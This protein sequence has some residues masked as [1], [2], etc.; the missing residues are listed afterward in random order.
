[1]SNF[2]KYY[3]ATLYVVA[4]LL[5]LTNFIT[6]VSGKMLALL[7]L[8]VQFAVLA[9]V[10]LRKP[11]SHI[12]VIAWSVI[13]MISGATMWLAIFFRGGVITQS[14]FDLIFRS[15]MLFLCLFFLVFARQVLQGQRDEI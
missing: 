8:S 4:S 14:N 10:Y 2:K 7:P 3:V 12:V 15:S 13:G 11:W 1:M 9:A 5:L 6:L